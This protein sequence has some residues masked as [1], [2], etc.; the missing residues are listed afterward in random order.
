MFVQL[1]KYLHLFF[2][3]RNSHDANQEVKSRR[4][5]LRPTGG[6]E[7]ALSVF[8]LFAPSSVNDPQGSGA[9]LSSRSRRLFPSVGAPQ[10]GRPPARLPLVVGR[11]EQTRSPHIRGARSVHVHVI[12]YLQ[13]LA[14]AR[15]PSARVVPWYLER[16]PSEPA[17]AVADPDRNS[18][19][20]S[21]PC[22]IGGWIGSDWPVKMRDM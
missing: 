15:R 9:P 7:R 21:F 6:R 12:I 3:N 18:H 5:R 1:F 22:L 8:I 17:A 20:P 14:R 10:D 16:S 4:E 2:S 11:R 13:T 19:R